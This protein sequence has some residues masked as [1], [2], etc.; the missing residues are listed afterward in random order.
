LLVANTEK[1]V[2]HVDLVCTMAEISE[3]T[4]EPHEV[5]IQRIEGGDVVECGSSGTAEYPLGFCQ[6]YAAGMQEQ[7][8]TMT[9]RDDSCSEFFDLFWIERPVDCG[10]GSGD[11]AR[12]DLARR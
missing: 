12:S 10:N 8:A 1:L 2:R 3:R 11:G 4:G 5:W 6:A 7:L 9:M